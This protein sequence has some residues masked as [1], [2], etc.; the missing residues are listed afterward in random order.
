MPLRFHIQILRLSR[1]QTHS[2]CPPSD[3]RPPFSPA[4]PLIPDQSPSPFPRSRCPHGTRGPM[5]PHWNIF[6]SLSLRKRLLSSSHMSQRGPPSSPLLPP[7]PVPR[8]PPPAA[9]A[10][11]RSRTTRARSARKTAT[12]YTSMRSIVAWAIPR[13][14]RPRP[15]R[16]PER[17]G[18][19]EPCIPLSRSRTPS[20]SSLVAA[21]SHDA[22]RFAAPLPGG[23]GSAGKDE[24]GGWGR[25]GWGLTSSAAPGGARVASRAGGGAG[26]G[27]MRG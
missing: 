18:V 9:R 12:S 27:K 1:T 26:G 6:I 4:P 13:R 2:K 24:D 14:C 10:T 17:G 21:A 25:E 15:P 19:R 8:P 3:T 16:A 22:L 23:G 5:T 20:G 7:P 11:L